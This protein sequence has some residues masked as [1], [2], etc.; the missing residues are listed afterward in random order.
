MIHRNA[1]GVMAG[2]VNLQPP[3]G[4]HDD[5]TSMGEVAVISSPGELDNEI[6][7]SISRA[8]EIV[9]EV[10]MGTRKEII[11]CS[12]SHDDLSSISDNI[13]L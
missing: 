5:L 4:I 8:K 9:E 12:N 13:A 7:A 11:E 6:D 10:R 2:E 1:L 3:S